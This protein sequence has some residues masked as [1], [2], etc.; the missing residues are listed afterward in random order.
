MLWLAPPVEKETITCIGKLDVYF[1]INVTSK[2]DLN[3]FLGII[4]STLQGFIQRN[5]QMKKFKLSL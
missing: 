2:Y 1:N 4:L 5:K 3:S